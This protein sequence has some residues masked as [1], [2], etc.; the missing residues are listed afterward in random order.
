MINDKD[1]EYMLQAIA[2]MREAG[3]VKKTGGAFGIVVVKD[4]EVIGASGNSV[5]RDNDRS[6]SP[7]RSKRYSSGL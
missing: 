7:R 4:G 2:L 3:V 6:Y 1:I 5:L